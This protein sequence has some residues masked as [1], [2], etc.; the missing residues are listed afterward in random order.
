MFL[1]LGKP[2]KQNLNLAT[3]PGGEWVTAKVEI[4]V[5]QS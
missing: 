4:R 2:E 3:Y 1:V 5:R